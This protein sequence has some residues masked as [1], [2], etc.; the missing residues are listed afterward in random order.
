[1]LT[2]QDK[3]NLFKGKRCLLYTYF[4]KKT[5]LKELDA[6]IRDADELLNKYKEVDF[7]N[8]YITA[9]QQSSRLLFEE[10]M[11]SQAVDNYLCRLFGNNSSEVRSRFGSIIAPN[12]ISEYAKIRWR[13]EE[14]RKLLIK[15]REELTK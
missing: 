14:K 12:L 4:R 15:F 13:L 3:N 6:L 1:M 7:Y 9:I 11:W 5:A 8:V 2:E 10:Q